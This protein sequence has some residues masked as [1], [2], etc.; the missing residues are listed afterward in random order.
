[1]KIIRYSSIL[2]VIMLCLWSCKKDQI[3]DTIEPVPYLNI[4]KSDLEQVV[5]NDQQILE[6]E[7]ESNV[8]YSVVTNHSWIQIE[9]NS[10]ENSKLIL[11]IAENDDQKPR[12]GLVLVRASNKE[13]KIIRIRQGGIA[14][15]ILANIEEITIEDEM[16]FTV[17]VQSN[18]EYSQNIPDW[19]TLVSSDVLPDGT[20]SEFAFE[21]D[22]SSMERS[23]SIQ[24]V[25]Q[26]ANWDINAAVLV[27]QSKTLFDD[28]DS[29]LPVAGL[30]DLVF[31]KNGPR[32]YS[33]FRHTIG[34]GAVKSPIISFSPEVNMYVSNFKKEDETYYKLNFAGNTEFI[35]G[36]KRQFTMEVYYKP[37]VQGEPKSTIIGAMEGQGIGVQQYTANKK[38]VMYLTTT[39]ASGWKDVGE[40]ITTA[41][42]YYH[43][44]FTYDGNKL[45]SYVNG[46]EEEVLN[47]TGAVTLSSNSA[48][49][50]FGFGGDAN[51]LGT[52]ADFFTGEI[53]YS[54]FYKEVKTDAEIAAMFGVINVR[55]N[56]TQ[57]SDLNNALIT[58]LPAK[59]EVASGNKKNAT[60]RLID[61]GW[62]LMS[63]TATTDAKLTEFLT[64]VNAL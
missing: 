49:H 25:G 50:W 62:K 26:G 3:E 30:F 36:F 53:A 46:V 37:T 47:L 34:V 23:E 42:Q 39:A 9:D 1:M 55:K 15:F 20:S 29:D 45:I 22:E 44:V 11:T 24:F 52:G 48:N 56:M 51:A 5:S 18:I 17:Q 4:E 31:T 58:L 16:V 19:I 27:K 35:E 41:G 10:A 38:T 64:E 43:M 12:E 59:L 7:V 14:P 28:P 6:I 13:R 54:K 40:T 61:R 63:N 21:V 60:Q 8:Q 32:D 57:I 33:P 2:L